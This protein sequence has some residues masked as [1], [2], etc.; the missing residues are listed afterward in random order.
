MSSVPEF[1]FHLQTTDGMAR[2][3]QLTNGALSKRQYLCP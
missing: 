2:R 3:G 1:G